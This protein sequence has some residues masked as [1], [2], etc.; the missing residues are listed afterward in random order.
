MIITADRTGVV[1]IAADEQTLERREAEAESG[2]LL[3]GVI[4][5]ATPA[6]RP[7]AAQTALTNAEP[8]LDYDA[9]FEDW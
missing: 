9:A 5:P 4:T 6:T 8:G 7:T 1:A 3:G 2:G